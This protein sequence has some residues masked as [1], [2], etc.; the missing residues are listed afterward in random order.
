MVDLHDHRHLQLRPRGGG[1][2][3]GV[4]RGGAS[5]GLPAGVAVAL[6]LVVLAPAFGGIVELVVMRGMRDALNRRRLVV[7][8]ALLAACLGIGVVG[9][10]EDE[11]ALST[12]S[13]RASRSR[14]SA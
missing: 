5:W 7:S 13:S 8:V 6:V 12:S 3:G 11:S 9:V 10:A 4:R 1:D 2:A 14:S